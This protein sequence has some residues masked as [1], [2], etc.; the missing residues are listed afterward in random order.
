[1]LGWSVDQGE[2]SG[3]PFDA[4]AP[5]ACSGQAFTAAARRFR[6][7]R[8]GRCRD[9]SRQKEAAQDDKT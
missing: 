2:K 8:V 5:L 9:P 6:N 3:L 4:L 1:M 7:D